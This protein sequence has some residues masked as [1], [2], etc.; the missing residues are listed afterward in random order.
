M[1][2][3]TG[4]KRCGY[5]CSLDVDGGYIDRMRGTSLSIGSPNAGI[6]F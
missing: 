1:W 5:R 4:A 3:D 2:A 6:K